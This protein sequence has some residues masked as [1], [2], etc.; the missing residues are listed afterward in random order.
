MIISEQ[1]KKRIL[2]LHQSYQNRNGSLVKEPNIKEK[3]QLNEG[4]VEVL[5]NI[6]DGIRD[7]GYNIFY[8]VKLLG[9]L[10]YSIPKW[11]FQK[12]LKRLEGESDDVYSTRIKKLMK[13]EVDRWLSIQEKKHPQYRVRRAISRVKK[14]LEELGDMTYDKLATHPDNFSDFQKELL[15]KNLEVTDSGVESKK[16]DQDYYDESMSFPTQPPAG[17]F[18]PDAPWTEMGSE[19]DDEDD[20]YPLQGDLPISMNEEY[21]RSYSIIKEE[22]SITPEGELLDD[23]IEFT[24]SDNEELRLEDEVNVVIWVG[25]ENFVFPG[26]NGTVSV[27]GTDEKNGNPKGVVIDEELQDGDESML[28]K[29][30]YLEWEDERW[31]FYPYYGDQ[32][33][34]S[35]NS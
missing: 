13:D 24:I 2:N 18:N 9:K 8:V 19:E 26:H 15:L 29:K 25:N 6:Y 23:G 12:E 3:E 4:V 27:I 30:G 16:F 21:G 20:S 10:G 17:E 32:S 34:Y 11:Y 1:E 33:Q 7:K 28:Y 31:N 14:E 35:F 5:Q 22:L